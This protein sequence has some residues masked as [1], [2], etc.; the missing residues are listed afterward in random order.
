MKI[1]FLYVGFCVLNI[2]C[3]YVVFLMII[4]CGDN[5]VN[6]D[7]LELDGEDMIFVMIS[8]VEDGSYMESY[9]DIF[10]IIGGR[11]FVDEWVLVKELF[12]SR[13]IFVVVF[14]EG[15]LVVWMMFC[16]EL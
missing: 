4:L 1:K 10:D 14:Y 8:W 12:V 16:E 2:C 3:L 5:V 15:F 9:V 6:F 13:V 11:M 7:S